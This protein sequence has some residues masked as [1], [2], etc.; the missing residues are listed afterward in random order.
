MHCLYVKQQVFRPIADH[1]CIQSSLLLA[2]KTR[3][4]C[5]SVRLDF[6]SRENLGALFLITE[7]D[8]PTAALLD[9]I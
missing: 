5:H 3:H 2:F 9:T 4:V 1:A 7:I 8:I 6:L